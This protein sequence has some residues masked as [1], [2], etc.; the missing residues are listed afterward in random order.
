MERHLLWRGEM[1]DSECIRSNQVP[2]AQQKLR[3]RQERRESIAQDQERGED[4]SGPMDR[5]SKGWL[6]RSSEMEF[7]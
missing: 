7:A 6:K 4:A 1:L 5:C 2:G 3:E